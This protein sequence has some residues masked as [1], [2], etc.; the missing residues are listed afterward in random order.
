[1]LCGIWTHRCHL[2]VNR[3]QFDRK[4]WSYGVI[5]VDYPTNLE[6]RPISELLE[7]QGWD[8]A[9]IL[10]MDIEG[11]EGTLFHTQESTI[12][13]LQY[14]DIIAIEIHHGIVDTKRIIDNIVSCDYIVESNNNDLVAYRK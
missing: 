4:E 5:E 8:R 1:M 11:G 10:K 13:I 3:D 9:E 2:E 7:E 6:G 14:F 12:E